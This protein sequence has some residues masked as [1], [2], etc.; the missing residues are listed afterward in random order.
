[1]AAGLP[2]GAALCPAECPHTF[3]RGPCLLKTSVG[4]APVLVLLGP[5]WLPLLLPASFKGS[6]DQ[7]RP[8]QKS[9]YAGHP[10]M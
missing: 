2:G 8:S 3:S 5:L 4:G 6:R 9:G 10:A 7:V 1:M